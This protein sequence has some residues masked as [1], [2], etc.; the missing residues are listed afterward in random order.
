MSDFE[1]A[2][3]NAIKIVFPNVANSACFFHLMQSFRR[4]ADMNDL[5]SLLD[6]DSA[7]MFRFKKLK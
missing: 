4:H 1:S 6:H 7:L 2:C 3:I 5:R